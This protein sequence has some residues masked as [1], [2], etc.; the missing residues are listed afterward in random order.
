MNENFF[1]L[2]DNKRSVIINAGFRVFS[3][4]SYRKSPMSEIAAE[5]GISKSLLFYYFRNKKELYLFLCKY[6]VEV[7]QQEIIRQ[8]CYEKEDFF[9][10]FLS[11]MK[12][13]VQLMKRYPDLSLFQLKAY[14]EKDNELRPEIN[15]LIGEY[16]G[17]ENQAE[18]LKLNKEQFVEGIDLEMMYMDIYLASEG[19]LWEKLQC[20]EIDADQM[21][22]DFIRMIEFWRKLYSRKV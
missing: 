5:A 19:Y 18:M 3:Q 2:P 7:T 12:V 20:D 15:K 6:S 13:K 10:V 17:Y 11:G 4:Y 8:K 16:S 21:E 22:K 9:E 14:Y 1:K